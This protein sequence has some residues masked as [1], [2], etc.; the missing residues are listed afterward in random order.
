MKPLNELVQELFVSIQPLDI[1][2]LEYLGEVDFDAAKTYVVNKTLPNIHLAFVYAATSKFG[3]AAAESVVGLQ[4]Q[5]EVI[6]QLRLQLQKRFA[7]VYLGN[8]GLAVL[9]GKTF[10][11]RNFETF[12]HPFIISVDDSN[13]G[14][15]YMGSPVDHVIN[16]LPQP[17]RKQHGTLLDDITVLDTLETVFSNTIYTSV[18]SGANADPSSIMAELGRELHLRVGK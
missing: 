6:H 5:Y 14:Y 8:Q 13:L 9:G 7:D 18:I 3:E 12:N 17:I 2:N 15:R 11:R 1:P 4:F 16:C 10:N